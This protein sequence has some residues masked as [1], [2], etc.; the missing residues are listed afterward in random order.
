[1]VGI[2]VTTHGM[3]AAG[4]I[5]SGA[6]IVGKQIHVEHISLTDTGIENYIQRLTKLLHNMRTDYKELL[7]L[8]DLKSGTP[9]NECFRYILQHGCDNEIKLIA[10]LNLPMYLE[11]VLASRDMSL[12]D[13]SLVAEKSGKLNIEL[14]VL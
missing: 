14:L 1:M 9:Y 5:D 3:M 10:G 11:T 13:L 2:L 8:C 12:E 7:I 6:M 4:V